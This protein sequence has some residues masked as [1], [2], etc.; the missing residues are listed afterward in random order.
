[1]PQVALVSEF[2]DLLSGKQLPATDSSSSSARQINQQLPTRDRS[3][4]SA[5]QLER[6]ADIARSSSSASSSAG[7][8]AQLPVL[9][10]T[11][12]VLS[13]RMRCVGAVRVRGV[14]AEESRSMCRSRL[15]RK[16]FKAGSIIA[17]NSSLA[18]HLCFV[19]AGHC[20]STGPGLSRAQH[21]HVSL[22]RIIYTCVSPCALLRA[23]THVH[24]RTA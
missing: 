12:N 24:A 22:A 10:L 6:T 16:E 15:K 23:V 11:A 4:K 19:E 21:L 7:T 20:V 13:L 5:Q 2:L 14:H 9:A 18:T 3:S 1:M 8:T 17:E